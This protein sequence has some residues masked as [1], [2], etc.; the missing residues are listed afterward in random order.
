MLS[1]AI[2]RYF[3]GHFPLNTLEWGI[4]APTIYLGHGTQIKRNC[5]GLLNCVLCTG[6]HIDACIVA[7]VGYDGELYF[8]R[9]LAWS[10]FSC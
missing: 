8:A 3:N 2:L 4:G 10:V 1:F 6:A 5:F 7:A 9:W